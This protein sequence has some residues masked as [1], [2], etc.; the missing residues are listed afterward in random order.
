MRAKAD[1]TMIK[2]LADIR[3]DSKARW[4]ERA[5]AAIIETILR[6]KKFL[7][8]GKKRKLNIRKKRKKHA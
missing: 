1:D 2:S 8:L 7:G 5:D 4:T 3:K 6:G